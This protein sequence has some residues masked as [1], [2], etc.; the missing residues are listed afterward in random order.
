[1]A[2]EQDDDLIFYGRRFSSRLLLG[3]ARYPSPAVLNDAIQAS[4]AQ[5]QPRM[6]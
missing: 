6:S 4:G 1:M 5:S 2:I 3:T